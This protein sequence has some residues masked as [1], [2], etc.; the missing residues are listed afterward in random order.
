MED[1]RQHPH[2]PRKKDSPAQGIDYSKRVN[3]E[4]RLA[5][6]QFL[7]TLR[8]STR[9]NSRSTDRSRWRKILTLNG[10]DRAYTLSHNAPSSFVVVT[11]ARRL[12][13]SLE[14]QSHRKLNIP[15]SS[16][17]QKRIPDSDIGRNRDRQKPDS[18][19][20]YRIDSVET[21]IHRKSRQQRRREV[22]V[23]QDVEH[24]SSNL[25]LNLL[26]E[27]RSLEQ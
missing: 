15:R 17:T 23:I 14:C 8:H 9:I 10:A 21:R 2:L 6:A 25:Q 19:P 3:G 18:P 4:E 20:G 22:R 1:L 11:P 24:L 27:R 26:A 16:P 12:I 5:V 13:S 7:D